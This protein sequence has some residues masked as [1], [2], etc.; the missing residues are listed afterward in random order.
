[1]NI[2]LSQLLGWIS[3]L[4]TFG[5]VNA[6]DQ[7]TLTAAQIV[8]GSLLGVCGLLAALFAQ[9]TAIRRARQAQHVR[10]P[11][12]AVHPPVRRG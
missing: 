8:C 4:L 1:M 5:V 7:G 12:R 11:V 6:A 3:L 10:V 9:C 2:R